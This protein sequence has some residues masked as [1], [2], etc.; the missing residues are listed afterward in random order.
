MFRQQGAQESQEA[1]SCSETAHVPKHGVALVRS[2]QLGKQIDRAE[3][4]EVARSESHQKRQIERHV[5]CSVVGSQ[6]PEQK[7]QR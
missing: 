1:H 7:W 3:I 2:V 5:L 6:T 4:N